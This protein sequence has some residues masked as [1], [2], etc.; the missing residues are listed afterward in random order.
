[1]YV[2]LANFCGQLLQARPGITEVNFWELFEWKFLRFKCF[3]CPSCWPI[4]QYQRAEWQIVFICLKCKKMRAKNKSRAQQQVI[5]RCDD[6]RLAFR[7]YL[8]TAAEMFC[9][10]CSDKFFNYLSQQTLKLLQSFFL[11]LRK[12]RVF[13][14]FLAAI[15]SR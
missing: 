4:K 9:N 15:L 12:M 2:Q 1:M 14:T 5:G 11:W 10:V 3:Y 8:Q 13:S 7:I 6:V